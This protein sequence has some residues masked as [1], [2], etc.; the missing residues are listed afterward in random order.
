MKEHLTQAEGH[1]ELAMHQE[2]WDTLEELPP[3]DRTEPLVLELKLRILTAL[4][5]WE[6][7]GY[8]ANVLIASAIEPEKSLHR[9]G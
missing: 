8:V 4:S 6:L 9:Q 7:G 2:A 5:Q 1:F 3:I